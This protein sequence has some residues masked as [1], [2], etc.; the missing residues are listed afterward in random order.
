MYMYI[1]MR[2]DLERVFSALLLSGELLYTSV[3][4]SYALTI[5]YICTVYYVYSMCYRTLLKQGP[6]GGRPI[7]RRVVIVTPGSLV[8]V[9][10]TSTL[11]ST[12]CFI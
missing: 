2:W 1:G 12:E 11:L 7:V 4:G 8:K 5:V 9:C 3:H 10:D 6:Y